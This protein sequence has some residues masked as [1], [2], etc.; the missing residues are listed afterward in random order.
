[1]DIQ[2]LLIVIIY[3]DH[4]CKEDHGWV[5]C[6]KKKTKDIRCWSK[7]VSWFLFIDGWGTERYDHSQYLYVHKVTYAC[8]RFTCGLL[9][10]LIHKE[11]IQHSTA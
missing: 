11:A 8:I 1:M 5:M 6:P 9:N 10:E 3:L 4:V 7:V 2:E